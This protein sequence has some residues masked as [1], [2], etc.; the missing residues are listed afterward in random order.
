VVI[1]AGTAVTVE[2]VRANGTGW[3]WEGGVIA[4][5]PD[6]LR[7]S[8]PDHTAALPLV[9]WPDGPVAPFGH[10]T[11]EAMQAGLSGLFAGGV[12]ELVRRAADALSG[13][14]LV[15]ATGGWASWLA[16]H[17]EF[18]ARIEPTLILDGVRALAQP[19]ASPYPSA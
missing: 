7:R 16:K 15:V 1:C 12:A 11:P 9:D 18:V 13:R 8:L 6:L 17:T 10:T 19:H 3:I 2:S 4:P 14:P 5:G